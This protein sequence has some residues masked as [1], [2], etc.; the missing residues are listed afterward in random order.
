M[1]NENINALNELDKAQV[2][3]FVGDRQETIYKGLYLGSAIKDKKDGSGQYG[4]VSLYFKG[5]S[6]KGTPWYSVQEQYLNV[7]KLL[8]LTKGL[9]FQ[10]EVEATF[11]TGNTPGG[12]QRLCSLS[13]IK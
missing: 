8:D 7:D 10:C 4:I 6:T 13:Q 9:D 2:N 5:V 11:T 12:K 3:N 1:N